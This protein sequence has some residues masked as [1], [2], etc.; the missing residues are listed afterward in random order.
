M[1][2]SRAPHRAPVFSPARRTLV[3]GLVAAACCLPALAQPAGEPVRLGALVSV[4]GNPANGL[5]SLAGY[6]MAVNEINKSGGILGRQ[7]DL[8]VG[9]DANDPTQA[10]TAVKRLIS[11]DRIQVLVGPMVSQATLAIAPVLTEARIANISVSG[12]SAITPKVAP[13][14]FS[15]FTS[16]EAVSEAMTDYIANVLK[17]KSAA[18]ITDTGSQGKS[19]Q[20]NLQRMLAARG[21]KVT[22]TQQ[23]EPHI[24]DMTSQIL[25]LRRGNPEVLLQVSST[26]DD[27]GSI[28]KNLDEVGWKVKLVSNSAALNVP[29]VM[30]TGGPDAFS[31]G[32]TAGQLLKAYTYCPGDAVGQ[33]EFGKF[34]TKLKA[35]DSKNFAQL[36]QQVVSMAYDGVYIVKAAIEATQ[37]FD[38]PVLA[39]WIEK[40]AQTVKGRINGPLSASPTNHFL[41]GTDAI[42]FVTRPDKKRE[43]GLPERS[44]M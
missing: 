42:V 38:G 34:V 44:C 43:D 30:R 23:H 4:T 33:T 9:D 26:G 19:A 24:T 40:N 10:V 12:S 31:N 16:I 41:V 35:A 6:K 20:D 29:M 22:G 1:K 27:T 39:A 36:N 17:V 18:I 8:F 28:L 11:K 21:I 25:S 15:L 3:A 2:P 13:Y 37:S 7:V 5:T 32:L 14:H